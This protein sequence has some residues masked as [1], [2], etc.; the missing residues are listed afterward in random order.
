MVE[1]RAEGFTP[2][3][4]VVFAAAI[5][6]E[7]SYR[8][9]THLCENITADGAIVAEPT[10]LQ[11]VIASKGCL[12][13]RVT[14]TGRAAHSSKPH[15]GANA[16]SGMAWLIVALEED[17]SLDGACHPLVGAP[18][19]NVGVIRG[20]AQVNIV[21]EECFIEV[22]RRLIPGEEP[23]SVR[24][25]YEQM[26]ESLRARFPDLQVTHMSLLEDWPMETSA[27]SHIVCAAHRA[28]EKLGLRSGPAGVPFG[29]DASKFNRAGIP[30]IVLGP[31]SIDQAHTASEYVAVDQVEQAVAVYKAII[32]E[33]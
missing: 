17:A 31:G 4:D 1:L 23:S 27:E 28:L 11:M 3:C 21:P 7:H 10:D 15:L 26:S 12:R 8:G 6:E 30:S 5:D 32:R 16:I 29:S 14:V 18:T 20:G 13:W 22:D 2:S 33:F 25:Q 24:R 9:A 19:L